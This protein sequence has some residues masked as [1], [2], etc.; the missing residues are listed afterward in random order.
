M[1]WTE[2]I[3]QNEI[4]IKTFASAQSKSKRKQLQMCVL[5]T[6]INTYRRNEISMYHRFS[7]IIHENRN[8]SRKRQ[9]ERT[10]IF[11]HLHQ[12]RKKCSLFFFSFSFWS[13]YQQQSKAETVSVHFSIPIQHFAVHFP[14]SECFRLGY[15]SFCIELYWKRK[16]GRR[17][18]VL[19]RSQANPIIQLK[20]K[21]K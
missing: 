6:T 3:E 16:N 9:C 7:L 18:N 15:V 21:Q 19:R 10:Y 1:K 12:Q 2:N 11:L 8:V 4:K 20:L 13:N 17:K 5:L 14:F